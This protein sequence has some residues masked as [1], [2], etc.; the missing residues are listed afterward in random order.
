MKKSNAGQGN[1]NSFTWLQY[2][3]AAGWHNLDVSAKGKAELK[4]FNL[5]HA[6]SLSI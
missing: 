3:G 2:N 1:W 4:F 6:V 5:K